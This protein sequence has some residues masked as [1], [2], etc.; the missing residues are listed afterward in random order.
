MRAVSYP[1]YVV[2]PL[3]VDVPDPETH[4]SRLG[5]DLL[6]IRPV[7]GAIMIGSSVYLM[8]GTFDALWSFVMTDLDAPKWMARAGITVFAVPLI[9]LGPYG[10]KL[11]QRFG[12]FRLGSL[13]LVFG[14]YPSWRAAR[15][16]P[17]EALRR[18]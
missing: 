14:A 4:T 17:I 18:E 3:L 5:L 8:I 11:V 2:V 7:A 13:G 6:K 16:D 1:A 12:A 15:L 9:I 10:G